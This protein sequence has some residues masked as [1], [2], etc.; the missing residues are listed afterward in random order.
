MASS[1]LFT[2]FRPSRVCPVQRRSYSRCAFPGPGSRLTAWFGPHRSAASGAF[3]PVR[4]RFSPLTRPWRRPIGENPIRHGAPFRNRS[5]H[6]SGDYPIFNDADEIYRIVQA[7]LPKSP[8]G[9]RV[10]LV[11]VAHKMCALLATPVIGAQYRQSSSG[12]LDPL[13]AALGDDRSLRAAVVHCA[14]FA[15]LKNSIYGLRR[16]RP[17][18]LRFNGRCLTMRCVS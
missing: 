4:G 5:R 12:R 15:R 2:D 6:S 17:T 10:L 13:G 14:V 9:A 16:T 3:W 7:G 11:R 8:S 18:S 1:P